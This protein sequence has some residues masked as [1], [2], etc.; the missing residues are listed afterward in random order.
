M[1]TYMV[2]P[3]ILKLCITFFI[4]DD[5]LYGDSHHIEIVHYMASSFIQ[6][7]TKKGLSSSVLLTTLKYN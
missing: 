7:V 6:C 2:I 1:I 4:S 5:Y 3:T